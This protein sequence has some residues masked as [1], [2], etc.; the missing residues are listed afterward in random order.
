MNIITMPQN[1]ED[2]E[3]TMQPAQMQP[4]RPKL[5]AGAAAH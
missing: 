1:I 5:F 2:A 4:H 3:Q